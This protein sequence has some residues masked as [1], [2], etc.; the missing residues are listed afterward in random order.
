MNAGL[1]EVNG[2]GLLSTTGMSNSGTIRVTAAALDVGVGARDFTN[3]GSIDLR[4]G[5]GLVFA[6]ELTGL[7]LLDKTRAMIISGRNGGAWN[8]TGIQ[9]AT[10]QTS[11]T[12]AVG[13]VSASSAVTWMGVPVRI[14]DILVRQTLL[15]DTNLDGNVDFTDLAKMAQ[16]YNKPL[17]VSGASWWAAGDF[18]YD[19]QVD[20]LDLACLAQNYNTAL[21]A[22][23]I[24]GA[25]PTFEQDLAAAF[26]SVPEPAFLAPLLAAGGL[27]LFGRRPRR[28]I[29]RT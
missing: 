11:A 18:N 26:A 14:G 12:S 22:A 6:P 7:G 25:T 20:F 24:P 27:A 13:Y 4:S 1:I 21:T 23:P 3:S 15:G 28:R 17:T 8:G 10:A 5:A 16:Y 29:G 9:S 2:G 19:G